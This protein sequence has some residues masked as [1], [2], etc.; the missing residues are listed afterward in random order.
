IT[1]C[2]NVE[3]PAAYAGLPQKAR[4]E[5]AAALLARL[6]LGERLHYRPGQLSGGQQQRVSIARALMNG[7]RIILADEPTGALDS[8]TGTEVL[9]LLR[10]LAAQG[11]TIILI[12]HDHGIA[13]AAQR[14][15]EIRDGRIVSDS[16]NDGAEQAAPDGPH[17]EGSSALGPTLQVLSKK[18]SAVSVLADMHEAFRSGARALGANP[19]RTMLTLLGI[20]IGV[21]SVIA[22]LA[23][24]EG[25]RQDVVARMASFGA[26]RLYVIPGGESSRGP[27]GRL[28][29]EDVPY[30][31]SVPNVTAAMP[32]LQG[33]VTVR[34][35]NIDYPTQGIAIT[36]DFPRILSWP[37]ER[38]VFFTVEDEHRLATVAVIGAKL[39]ARMFP[40]GSDPIRRSI[41][42]DGVPFQVIGVLAAKGSGGAG[43][44]EDDTIVFPYPTGAARVFG[45]QELSW[46]SVLIDD[47]A[48]ARETEA[49][50]VRVLERA[51]GV[52]DFRV[53]NQA[54][55]IEAQSRT[56]DTMTLL[57][58]ATAAI[59]LLVGGIGVMNVMLM[60]VG[61]RTREIGIRMATGAR[62][63]DILRQFLTEAVMVAGTGG[64]AGAVI[65]IAAG[66]VAAHAFAMPVIFT[67][68]A[69]L[70]AVL[71]ALVTGLVFGF[72]PA[73]R[74][75]RL[76]PVAAL[77]RE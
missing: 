12:T 73:L 31:R 2:E 22:L 21:A 7:G 9:A 17:L 14:I 28:L 47:L 6:G 70:G 74:A 38:G 8:A 34:A 41:L 42:V 24:G 25:A 54:A 56:Q 62:T 61:E 15:V 53:F 27:G 65:G 26:N 72:M 52:R 4:H 48:Q 5:R 39:A 43:S 45:R 50:V 40:D 11:H 33:K 49:D 69:L 51:H 68:T 32:Y 44:D 37:V 63:S 75:A 71:T 77:A 76:E 67:G 59:S 29:P 30:V 16:G 13:R 60:T 10:Q 66:T 58:G 1:A 46:I 19:F 57:L 55:S 18:T 35:G 23:I 3:V 36:T 64:I 20:I